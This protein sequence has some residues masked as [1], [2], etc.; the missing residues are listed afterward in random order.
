M[1]MMMMM[2]MMI[3]MIIII[4]IMTEIDK[5]IKRKTSRALIKHIPSAMLFQLAGDRIVPL[6]DSHSEL[7]VLAKDPLGPPADQPN[8]PSSDL[9]LLLLPVLLFLAEIQ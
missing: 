6:P 5:Q 2:M 7:L 3:M 1:M 4:M 9:L 8:W